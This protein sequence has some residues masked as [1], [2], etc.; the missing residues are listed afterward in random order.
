MQEVVDGF[1]NI[2]FRDK[3]ELLV[4]FTELIKEAGYSPLFAEEYSKFRIEIIDA[5]AFNVDGPFPR[6][7]SQML[8]QALS[9]RISSLSYDITLSGMEGEDLTN[10][11]WATYFT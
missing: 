7:V 3:P 9:N 11:D 1:T 6:L 4:K 5:L 2:I 10:L 8:N